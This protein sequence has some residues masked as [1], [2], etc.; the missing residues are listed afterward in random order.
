MSAWVNAAL[1]KQATHERRL[2]ALDAFFAAYEE[3]HG[4]FAD[5]E[6]ADARRHFSERAIVVRGAVAGN[7]GRLGG[8][9]R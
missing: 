8:R 3:E 6:M 2:D 5:A 7:P 9:T 4:A 1:E